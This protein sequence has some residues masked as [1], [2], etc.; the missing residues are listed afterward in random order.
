MGG[1]RLSMYFLGSTFRMMPAILLAETVIV[2]CPLPCVF[3]PAALFSVQNF[4][5][6]VVL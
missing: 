4:G 3:W 2:N 6:L 5:N 1:G